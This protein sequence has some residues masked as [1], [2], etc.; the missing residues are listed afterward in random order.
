METGSIISIG[1]DEIPYYV[2][3]DKGYAAYCAN[4]EI[5]LI[6]STPKPFPTFEEFER[7]CNMKE[8]IYSKAIYN[9]FAQFQYEKTVEVFPNT[10]K[11]ILIRYTDNIRD[12][13]HESGH[14]ISTKDDERDSGE[15]VDIFLKDYEVRESVKTVEIFPEVGKEYEFEFKSGIKK[16]GILYGYW[17]K[18]SGV[19]AIIRPI[20]PSRL[21]Q[22][23][24]RKSELSKDELIELVEL[25]EEER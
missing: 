22:L 2:Q 4:H 24:A 23:K 12:Y 16:I 10:I 18:D 3:F 19:A 6:E 1:N 15:F 7:W 20:Q 11:E 5:E 8:I 21:E 14:S 25:M 17:I 13:E 9:Y